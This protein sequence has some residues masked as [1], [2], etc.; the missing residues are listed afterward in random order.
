LQKNPV[1]EDCCSYSPRENSSIWS[2]LLLHS[3]LD[4]LGGGTTRIVARE[5]D[6]NRSQSFDFFFLLG[7]CGVIQ[8]T[9]VRKGVLTFI[10]F[11]KN[12]LSKPNLCHQKTV[13]VTF[14]QPAEPPAPS[15]VSIFFKVI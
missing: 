6:G 4:G 2:N 12:A 9:E 15:G 14:S 11:K 8:A 10:N 7:L 1:C 13:G 3:G 5:G